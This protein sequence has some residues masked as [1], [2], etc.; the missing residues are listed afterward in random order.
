M[1]DLK[2]YGHNNHC[3]SLIDGIIRPARGGAGYDPLISGSIRAGVSSVE[4]NKFK[5]SVVLIGVLWD[6]PDTIMFSYIQ[7]PRN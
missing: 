4:R 7:M 1:S 3:V 2:Y 5:N 6:R